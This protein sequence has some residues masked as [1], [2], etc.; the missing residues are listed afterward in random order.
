M[1][2]R[3]PRPV[4]SPAR[5]LAGFTLIELVVALALLALL[6]S[7]A[8]PRFFG[9][10]E[11]DERLFV[12]QVAAALRHARSVA[13]AT[14]CPVEARFGGG[15]VS[16]AQQTGCAGAVYGQAV[17]DPANGAAG[18]AR[19]AP[20]GVGLASD[21]DPLRFDALGRALDVGGAVRSA[22]V[23]VGAAA[24]DVVGET[25]LVRAP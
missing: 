12:Q 6:A 21:V 19:S 23:T 14:G 8:A 25:G 2:L 22:R 1:S 13:V 5:R 4:R 18:Y 10:R 15:S 9:R 7:I 17:P 20:P 3:R 16:L 11:L 24:I